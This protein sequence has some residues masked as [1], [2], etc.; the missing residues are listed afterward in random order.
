MNIPDEQAPQ[1]LFHHRALAEIGGRYDPGLRI[2]F[3]E[4]G[5]DLLGA[6]ARNTQIQDDQI[7]PIHVFLVQRDRFGSTVDADDL[8][9]MTDD[10]LTD[11]PLTDIA[12]A[13]HDGSVNL[14]DFA[15]FSEHWLLEFE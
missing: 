1:L 11:E 4:P 2:Q 8:V 14:S 9:R 13:Y 12:P 5:Q 3:L 6:H 15:A 7:D 10:W